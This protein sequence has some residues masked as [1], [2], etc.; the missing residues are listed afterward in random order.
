VQERVPVSSHPLLRGRNLGKRSTP[1]S[2]LFFFSLSEILR[3]RSVRI[4]RFFSS[5]LSSFDAS[6]E[7]VEEGVKIR[8][9]ACL[10]SLFRA[11]SRRE[12]HGRFLAF[13]FFSGIRTPDARPSPL[14]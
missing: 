11:S 10:P 14:S 3:A 9:R 7:T 1:S 2:S 12:T 5:P 4:G 6:G 13:P 8:G